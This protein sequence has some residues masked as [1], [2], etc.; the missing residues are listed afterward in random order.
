MDFNKLFK[1]IIEEAEEYRG[2]H[3]APDKESGSPLYD[4]TLNGIYPSDFYTSPAN[5]YVS[6]D[7]E[8]ESWGIVHRYKGRANRLIKI[9]RAV[10][11]FNYELDKELK[12]INYLIY[13]KEKWGFFPTEIDNEIL[14]KKYQEEFKYNNEKFKEWLDISSSELEE[15]KKKTE[16][17]KINPG[18]WVTISLNYA[19][20]HGRSSLN[21]RY[22][23]ITKTVKARDIYTEGN[24]LAE[25]GYDPS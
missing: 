22:K 17:I 24:S 9:Y 13:Y 19:K 15:K 1:Y 5:W 11:N 18:D 16:K 25:W 12:D 2:E 20:D 14:R 4:V 6:S 21:N 7:E 10:P 23:I 8:K 3:K